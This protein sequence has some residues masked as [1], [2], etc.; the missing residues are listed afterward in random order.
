[1]NK[2]FKIFQHFC[3]KFRQIV[4]PKLTSSDQP[5]Y[6][7]LN[8]IFGFFFLIPTFGLLY[9]LFTYDMLSDKYVPHFFALFLLCSLMGF[10]T[11]RKVFEKITTISNA[12]TQSLKTE[13]ES[14]G[15][16]KGADEVENISKSLTL[17]E[18]QLSRTSSQLEKKTSEISILKELSD[19]CYVT[20]DPEELLYVTL[21]RGLKIANADIGSILILE[22]T[23]H[24]HFIVKANIGNTE[25]L[26]I[27]DT[28]DF[29][30]SI[31]KYAVINKAPFLIENIEEDTRLG[32]LRNNPQYGSK[33][34]VCI[35]IKTIKDIIGVMTLS[36]KSDPAIFTHQEVEGL[37]PL[38]SN[39][40]FTYENL[41]L[42]KEME[43]STRTHD[44]MGHLINCPWGIQRTTPDGRV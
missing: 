5:L 12:F 8:I 42:L 37:I 27:G 4:L 29:R 23:P 11:L 17:F 20:F 9:F 36:R 14:N 32:R 13:F 10:I 39:A 24:K 35:P 44:A 6:H 1:M 19:L 15:V 28:V 34:F 26:T 30:T 25:H 21:E 22:N 43:A 40:A 7:K 41:R 38:V 33:S 18:K 31:A 3:W 16:I 2:P